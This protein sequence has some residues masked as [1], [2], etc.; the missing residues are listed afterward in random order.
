MTRTGPLYARDFP[1]PRREWE[2]PPSP[3]VR[4]LLMSDG[5]LRQAVSNTDSAAIEAA[6]TITCAATVSVSVGLFNLEHYKYVETRD[7]MVAR[8]WLSS[9]CRVLD[10]L[11]VVLDD[12]NDVSFLRTRL[13]DAAEDAVA[14]LTAVQLG[15][16]ER[17]LA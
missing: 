13:E 10:P 8:V 4:V 5:S 7:G 16:V 3:T 6:S 9:T 1:P 17:L 2:A 15:A 14:R 11:A 12:I